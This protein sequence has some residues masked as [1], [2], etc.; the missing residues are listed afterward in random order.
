MRH[1][2][3]PEL[4]RVP[5][6]EVVLQIKKLGV[7]GSAQSQSVGDQNGSVGS[8]D[9]VEFLKNALEPPDPKAVAAAVATLRE[10][11]ALER[12]R[13]NNS[14]KNGQ[15]E[16]KQPD[17]GGDLTP[18]GHHLA[19]LPVE[20]RVAKMLVYGALLSCVSPVL[21]IAACLSYKSP[22]LDGRSGAGATGRYVLRV[23]QIQAHCFPIQDVNHFSFTNTG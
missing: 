23:S 5:L 22:F 17:G 12:L 4:H 15:T 1:H 18:L 21:T 2:Q 16:N 8:G 13:S 9:P 11:G 19:A 6:T 20:C 3:V 7:G 10:I 14:R